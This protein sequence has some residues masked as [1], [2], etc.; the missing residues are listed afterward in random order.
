MKSNTNVQA[1][2]P[3]K[4][5]ANASTIGGIL[6]VLSLASAGIGYALV[7]AHYAGTHTA[8]SA[9]E[10]VD[11]AVADGT[12]HVTGILFSIPFLVGA[13]ALAILAMIFILTRLRKVKTGGLIASIILIAL[14]VWS[15]CV[16]AA[17]FNHIKAH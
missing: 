12:L 9:A 17:A 5:S 8:A 16:V 11:Q 7:N 2:A 15:I 10:K 6:S 4:S 13:D 3:K 14:S 1:V